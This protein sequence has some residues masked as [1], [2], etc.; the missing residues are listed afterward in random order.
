MRYVWEKFL[1]RVNVYAPGTDH[2]WAYTALVVPVFN[3]T[4]AFTKVPLPKPKCLFATLGPPEPSRICSEKDTGVRHVR[5]H[6]W[7]P[8]FRT[9]ICA[10]HVASR[11]GAWGTLPLVAFSLGKDTASCKGGFGLRQDFT[12]PIAAFGFVIRM[13]NFQRHTFGFTGGTPAL[14]VIQQ[15]ITLVITRTLLLLFDAANFRVL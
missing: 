6:G 2:H 1:H 11:Q 14:P 7:L 10:T 8:L 5:W 13:S 15:P 4:L 12:G 9:S 3:D